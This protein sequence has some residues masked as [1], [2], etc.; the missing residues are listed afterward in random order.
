MAP[1]VLEDDARARDEVVT[2]AGKAGD[3]QSRE[4]PADDPDL[5][6][7]TDPMTFALLGRG[8]LSARDAIESGA[9]TVEGDAAAAERCA[10]LFAA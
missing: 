6:L 7:C 3:I 2:I 4:G 10:A 8:E 1:A 5:V 9:L